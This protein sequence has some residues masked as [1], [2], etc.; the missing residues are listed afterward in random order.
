MGMRRSNERA[1]SIPCGCMP[2]WRISV[3]LALLLAILDIR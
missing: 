2:R 1:Y 3:G